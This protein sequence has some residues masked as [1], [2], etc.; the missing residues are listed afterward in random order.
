MNTVLD[1]NEGCFN[2]G[3]KLETFTAK[4]RPSVLVSSITKDMEGS[5]FMA[6][7]LPEL[8][9]AS[10]VPVGVTLPSGKRSISSGKQSFKIQLPSFD[11]F[12]TPPFTRGSYTAPVK[13]LSIPEQ[14]SEVNG[15]RSSSPGSIVGGRLP[16][17]IGFAPLLTPPDDSTFNSHK[18]TTSSVKAHSRDTPFLSSNQNVESIH[19]NVQEV[20]S[21]QP[22]ATTFIPEVAPS[23]P[24]VPMPEVNSEGAKDIKTSP[25]LSSQDVSGTSS[26]L[27]S[28]ISA[29]RKSECKCFFKIKHGLTGQQCQSYLHIV[30]L[31]KLSAFFHMLF[32]A[33]L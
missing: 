2:V 16:V 21:N 30:I 10:S 5:A 19:P 6:S 22:V 20:T 29:T 8:K 1:A 32:L 15:A 12:W 11:L 9:R 27:D 24:E 25:N 23:M 14:H 4:D 18:V 31:E 33:L 3:R 7:S 28:A 17:H 13:S 26:W